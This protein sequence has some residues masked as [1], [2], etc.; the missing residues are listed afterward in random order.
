MELKPGGSLSGGDAIIDAVAG[1]SA[2]F[3]DCPMAGSSSGGCQ[4]SL[5]MKEPLGR[6]RGQHDRNRN[7][8]SQHRRGEV[9]M[10]DSVKD[11]REQTDAP[12]GLQIIPQGNFI[13]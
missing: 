4:F 2:H 1:S 11:G 12:E 10:T 3:E 6:N 8:L 9:A 13:F 7:R 5:G